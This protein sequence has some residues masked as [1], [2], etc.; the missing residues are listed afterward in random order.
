MVQQP[1][2]IL[3]DMK[4]LKVVLTTRYHAIALRGKVFGLLVCSKLLITVNF[5]RDFKSKYLSRINY[6]KSGSESFIQSRSD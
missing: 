5:K 1:V 3:L 2:S 4:E 6:T